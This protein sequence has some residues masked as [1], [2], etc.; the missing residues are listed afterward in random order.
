MAAKD[1]DD[2]KAKLAPLAYLDGTWHGDGVGPYGPYEM[3]AQVER[4]GRWLLLTSTIFKPKSDEATYVST[5]VYGYDESGLVLNF[6]DTAGSFR[7]EGK[8]TSDKGLR[9]DFKDGENW[10]RSEY[11]PK[12]AGKIHYRYESVYP[13]Q[14]SEVFEGD[15][16]AG[17]RSQRRG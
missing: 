7:F 1:D 5:Q 8:A 11:G 4:R 17:K 13:A 3:E 9:F 6:F 15:W 2:P 14:G 12:T 10:K 16:I